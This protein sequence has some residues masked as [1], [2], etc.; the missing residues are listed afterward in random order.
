VNIDKD[1][2]AAMSTPLVLAILLE[3]PSYGTRS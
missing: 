2:V 1:L 3:G